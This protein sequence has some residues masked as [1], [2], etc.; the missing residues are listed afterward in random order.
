MTHRLSCIMRSG[1]PPVTEE[2]KILEI[3]DLNRR[4]RTM[5]VAKTETQ[6]SC[7]VLS[8]AQLFCVFVLAYAKF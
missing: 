5:C 3:H 2:G 6:N 8:C 7:A 4:D 1:F